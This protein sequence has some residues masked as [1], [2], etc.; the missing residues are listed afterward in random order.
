M[1]LYYFG[2]SAEPL[3][4]VH[5]EAKGTSRRNECVVL[6]PPIGTEFLRSYRAFR[7]LAS[8]LAREGYDVLRFDYFGTGDSSGDCLQGS[9]ERWK[10]DIKIAVEELRDLSGVANVS[11]VGLR[12]G[13]TLASLACQELP[14]HKLVLW[15]PVIDGDEYLR[16]RITADSDYETEIDHDEVVRKSLE[17]NDPVGIMGFAWSADFREEVKTLSLD[18][19]RNVNSARTFLLVREE[20]EQTRQLQEVLGRNSGRFGYE[21]IE[22]P[23]EWG[24]FDAIGSLLLPQA[25]IKAVIAC[26]V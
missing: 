21:H 12:L 10:N 11:L 16:G 23:G 24:E 26:L 13:A 25:T 3:F 18:S 20:L 1:Q 5:H 22:H 19:F 17:T 7:Q 15:E 6:C 8:M 2:N 14:I 9:I 4:G